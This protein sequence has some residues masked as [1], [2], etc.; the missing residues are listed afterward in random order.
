[1]VNCIEIYILFCV[2]FGIQNVQVLLAESYYIWYDL[3]RRHWGSAIISTTVFLQ[4]NIWLYSGINRDK[5]MA[6]CGSARVM[7]Y[8]FE[9]NLRKNILIFRD[10]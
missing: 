3:R 5:Y 1:M 4:E 6:P 8:V 2:C 9:P 7:K 10:F